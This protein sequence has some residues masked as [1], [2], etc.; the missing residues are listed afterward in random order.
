M[1]DPSAVSAVL[2][3]LVPS[4]EEHR[5]RSRLPFVLGLSGLQGSGKSTWAA[6]LC[7]VLSQE[8]GYNTRALSIDDLY[9]DHPELV[10]VR[11]K[12]PENKLL[13]TRGQPGTHDESLAKK[14]FTDLFGDDSAEHGR[15]VRWPA[16]DKSLHQGQG[17]RVPEE[18]WETVSLDPPLQVLIFEGWC[19]GFQPLK[20]QSVA[21]KWQ[22][23]R[24]SRDGSGRSTTSTLADHRL[25]N[26]LQ[27]NENLARYCEAFM[28]PWR[29][30]G[31]LHLST[32]D[33]GNVYEWRLD[34]ERALRK[35][36]PGMTDEQVVQFV[37]G[38]MPA[39]ELFL[40]RLQ[41]QNMFAS[42]STQS[43]SR[44][45][46]QVSLDSARQIV[47]VKEL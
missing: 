34:Q 30:D 40:E 43:P 28:G 11:H 44:K 17:G 24:A 32:E 25:E 14:F 8:H 36:K 3:I 33:L 4:I 6:E 47:S 1:I 29:Y 18:Q 15:I 20:Q 9:H 27:I 10:A 21:D 38:Y 23:A 22:Q 42:G 19:L 2:T 41:T 37:R 45:H 26:L 7:K 46:I 31:F 35:T 13:G 12:Y 16:Y 5:R 39:H